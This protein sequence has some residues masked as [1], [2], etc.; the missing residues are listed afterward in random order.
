M[1]LHQATEREVDLYNSWRTRY[2]R[3]WRRVFDPIALQIGLTDN[4]MTADLSVIPLVLRSDYQQY[5]Q[6]I[7][8]SRLRS[9]VGQHH[10]DSLASIDIALDVN[11][12]IF[13]F[14][15]MI[16]SSSMNGINVD[17]LAWID[18]SASLYFDYDK[19]WMERFNARDP[20]DFEV[21]DHVKEIPIAIH[22]PSKDSLR[23]TAFLVGARSMLTSSAPNV[24]IWATT[25]Y[26]DY[27]YISISPRDTNT[28]E[29]T[30]RY[31]SL[32]NGID[33]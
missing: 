14:L 5:L 27:E 9:D 25:K 8:K 2:E 23:L 32:P 15:R 29:A 33:G 24:T 1:Q 19:D 21:N 30:L 11:A 28:S 12:P 6:L 10:K 4:E 18:G 13:G 22:I 16:M 3:K 7:G 31:V 20:W 26:K 17:P